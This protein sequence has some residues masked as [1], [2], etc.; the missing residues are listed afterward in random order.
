MWVY[1][2]EKKKERTRKNLKKKS[3]VQG[4]KSRMSAILGDIFVFSSRLSKENKKESEKMTKNRE[5]KKGTVR[6]RK[7]GEHGRKEDRGRY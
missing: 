1:E 3:L 5:N 7:G 4:I 2:C 6:E